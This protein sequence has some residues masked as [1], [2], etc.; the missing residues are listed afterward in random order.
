MKT[1]KKTQRKC[2]VA[3]LIVKVGGKLEGN[4]SQSINGDHQFCL[5]EI[6]VI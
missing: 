2:A 6:F 3:E 5:R 4:D 1:C